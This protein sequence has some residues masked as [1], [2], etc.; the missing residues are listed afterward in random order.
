MDV[1]TAVQR[2]R[3]A[4]VAHDVLD[5]FRRVAQARE[6]RRDRGVDDF[7]IAAAGEF[8]ELHQGEIRFDTRGVTVHYQRYRAGRGDTGNLRVTITVLDAQIQNAVRF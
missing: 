8:L 1:R 6:R 3:A 4:A 2:P 7:E 5:L